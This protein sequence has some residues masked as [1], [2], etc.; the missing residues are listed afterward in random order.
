MAIVVE[1]QP[2]DAMYGLAQKAGSAQFE[3]NRQ[4]QRDK[5]QL[6][7]IQMGHENRKMQ[8]MEEAQARARQEEMQYQAMM[9]VARKQIDMQLD[10]QRYMRQKMELQTTLD[11]I[12]GSDD[13]SETEKEQ[14]SIQATA[15]F[16]GVGTGI[17]PSSFSASASKA[18]QNQVLLG[19]YRKKALDDIQS[20]VNSGE[21]SAQ[22]GQNEAAIA[23]ITGVKID[24]PNEQ[25][26]KI[27]DEKFER[28]SQVRDSYKKSFYTDKKGNPIDAET[29]EPI[30]KGT[31]KYEQWQVMNRQLQEAQ[32]GVKETQTS[33]DDMRM[34]AEFQQ[35]AA[36]VP[37]Y[38]ELIK[39]LG[40]KRAF[41]EWKTTQPIS[42]TYKERKPAF[43]KKHPILKSAMMSQPAHLSPMMASELML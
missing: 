33:V 8:F 4:Q 39:E 25:V 43:F 3:E 30:K 28:L 14:L 22:Q 34:L 32:E 10:S 24:S 21:I 37:E 12:S 17:S 15:K 1:H 26:A 36:K 5:E 27:I 2:V 20:R 40:Y 11:M 29:D 6:M 31:P 19:A 18:L 9:L 42:S 13:L 7:K 23:G 35:K 41:E 16:A 38:Q